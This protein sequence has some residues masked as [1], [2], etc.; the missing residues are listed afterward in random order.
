VPFL[1]MLV[2]Q[3]YRADSRQAAQVDRLLDST[4]SV[5]P[6][7]ATGASSVEMTSPWWEQDASVFGD[8][9][10]LFQRREPPL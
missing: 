6:A 7:R 9:A 5:A 4:S 2:Y 10:G 3:W 1:T 8:R